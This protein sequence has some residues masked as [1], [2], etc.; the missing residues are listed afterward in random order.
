MQ[1]H[2]LS[3]QATPEQVQQYGLDSR[4]DHHFDVTPGRTYTVIGLTMVAGSWASGVGVALDLLDDFGRWSIQPLFLFEVVDP[5]PSQ[6]WIAKKVGEAELALWPESFFQDF[7][8]DHLT[9]GLPEEVAD[10]KRVCA[11][12]DAE[13]AE[14]EMAAEAP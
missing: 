9:D 4:V 11:L 7:Y 3:N 5:R 2:C 1:V 6:Y 14:D 10:F 13:F 12:L 8:H